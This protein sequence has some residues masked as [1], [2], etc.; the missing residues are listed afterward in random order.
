MRTK[1]Q[2]KHHDYYLFLLSQCCIFIMMAFCY[3]NEALMESLDIYLVTAATI[4]MFIP[5]GLINDLLDKNTVGSREKSDLPEW[6][7]NFTLTQN[8]IKFF[9]LITLTLYIYSNQWCM[10][11]L[12]LLPLVLATIYMVIPRKL[13][14]MIYKES[15]DTKEYC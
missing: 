13:M 10:E 12:G 2:K 1:A 9:C 15:R 11:V 8:I 6:K 7:I 14:Y 4:F 3:F 5:R